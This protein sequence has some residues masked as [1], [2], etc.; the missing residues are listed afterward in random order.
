LIFVLKILVSAVNST[1]GYHCS[2]SAR[3]G[4]RP[5]SGWLY[6]LIYGT[7][8]QEQEKNNKLV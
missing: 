7:P 3:D 2:R 1:S 6:G 8:K 5:N 4:K